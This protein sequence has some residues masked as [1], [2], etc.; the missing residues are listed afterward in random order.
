[1]RILITGAAGFVGRHLTTR[2]AQA[3]HDLIG[4]EHR[5]QPEAHAWAAR[6]GLVL[7]EGNVADRETTAALVTA[8]AP[9]AV[10][11]LAA[12]TSV[13][14]S[15][16]DP[17]LTWRVNL[18]GTLNLLDAVRDHAPGARVLVVSSSEVY[19]K[20]PP[21]AQPITEDHP[22]RPVTPYAASKAAADLAA[23]QYAAGQGLDV[24][25]VR[26]FNHT[27]PGQSPRFVCADFARQVARL[28]ARGQPGQLHVGNLSAQ[29][30]F[31]DVRDIVR[32]YELA[33]QRGQTGAVYNLASGLPRPVS[34][35]AET[36]VAAARVPI[37]IVCDAKRHRPVDLP[38]VR[39]SAERFRAVAGWRPAIPLEQTLADLLAYWRERTAR[40][41]E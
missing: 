19:G 32:A 17:D 5:C 33:L 28:E 9:E 3:G 24:I 37:R 13:P 4:I 26:P 25:R 21:E 10:I 16:R 22:L 38:V 36:L 35:I 2:L 40:E 27:G 12:V 29:R 6:A 39:G 7:K 30:D 15:L 14:E 8:A 11:H 34:W 18:M 1:M 20:V 23:F 41:V 31:T